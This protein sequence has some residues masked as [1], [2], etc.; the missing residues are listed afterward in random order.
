MFVC[1]NY[2]A[3]LLRMYIMFSTGVPHINA[4]IRRVIY[5]F[6][7]VVGLGVIPS[8]KRI[9]RNLKCGLHEANVLKTN[10]QKRSF[11]EINAFDLIWSRTV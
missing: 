1:F 5:C 7:L 8:K 10:E 4:I 3:I 6:C 11:E 2:A 9:K